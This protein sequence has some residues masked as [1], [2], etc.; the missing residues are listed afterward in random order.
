[1]AATFKDDPLPCGLP[2]CRPPSVDELVGLVE[3]N[4][5]DSEP[6]LAGLVET[7]DD[8]SEPALAGLVK[9]NDD[10]SGPALVGLVVINN[11]ELEP[12][13]DT[14]GSEENDGSANSSGLSPANFASSGSNS[15]GA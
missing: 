8:D 3:T 1:M 15:S 2:F 7:G 9:I 11:G 4:G 10:G 13:E 14:I 12:R 6:A 5:G